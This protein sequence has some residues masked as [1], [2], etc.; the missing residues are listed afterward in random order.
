L[1]KAEFFGD[2]KYNLCPVNGEKELVAKLKTSGCEVLIND[3]LSTSKEYMDSLKRNIPNLKIVNFE[4]EGE[5]VTS[6]YVFPYV[7]Y[8][9]KKRRNYA[10]IPLS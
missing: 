1:T 5:G 8:I 3:I 4:D 7:K 6:G 10:I 2:I 9:L